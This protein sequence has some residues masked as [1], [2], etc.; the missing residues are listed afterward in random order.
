MSNC[1]ACTK[2]QYLLSVNGTLLSND[3]NFASLVD[4]ASLS[5]KRIPEINEPKKVSAQS[6]KAQAAPLA[7]TILVPIEVRFSWE[8]L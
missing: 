5:C 2:W 7:Y 6:G 1:I 8:R 4:G 3:D